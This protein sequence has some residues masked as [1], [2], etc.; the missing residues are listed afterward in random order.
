MTESAA[1][2]YKHNENI[3][4]VLV[5]SCLMLCSNRGRAPECLRLHE[6]ALQRNAG[7][8]QRK[9]ITASVSLQAR[10]PNAGPHA[11]AYTHAQVH[12]DPCMRSYTATMRTHMVWSTSSLF[13]EGLEGKEMVIGPS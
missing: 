4:S 2:S 6:L 1:V 8:M 7:D 13:L 9:V 10:C 5:K 11:N 12:A 3:S